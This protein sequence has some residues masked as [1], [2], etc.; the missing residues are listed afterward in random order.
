MDRSLL[1]TEELYEALIELENERVISNKINQES[2]NLLKGLKILVERFN[3][4]NILVDI[5]SVLRDIVGCEDIIVMNADVRRILRTQAA[6]SDFFYDMQ[7]EPQVFLNRVLKGDLS[8]SFDTKA[9]PEWQSQSEHLRNRIKSVIH[10]GLDFNEKE[11]LLICCDS[12]SN[13]FNRS[14]ADL[15]KRYSTLITQALI[16]MSSQEKITVLNANLMSMAHQAGMAEVAVSVIHNVGNVLN[17]VGVSVGIIKESMSNSIY[18]KIGLLTDML[19][20]HQSNLIEYFQNDEQ[21]KLIPDYL[22]LLFAEIQRNKLILDNEVNDLQQHYHLI[23]DILSA[24]DELT[25]PKSV[26]EPV[27]LAEVMDSSIHTVMRTDSM[28]TK[29]ITL[30]KDY[31]YTSSIMTN[32]TNLMQIFV[33][34]LK[35]AK[36]SVMELKEDMPR[37][38]NI[39]I[40][41]KKNLNE[42]ELRIKDNGIG[43]LPENLSKIFTFGF[44]T[45]QNGHGFG[46]HNSALIAKQLGGTLEVES[47]GFGNGALFI[48]TLPIDKEGV[49]QMKDKS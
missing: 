24:E 38:I 40:A 42:V 12:R 35:N 5:I 13:F 32:K 1:N 46:L 2:E 18:Q 43:I 29:N 27:S 17:S 26:S 44:T 3:E 33:N 9:I 19:K 30:N 45:K 8:I 34:L 7:L 37:K 15:I 49:R 25:G 31:R 39:S 20:K 28:L 47:D 11:T 4:K 23:K 10:I 16:N 22:M 21:G 6:T 14:H 36:E 48:L 41:R